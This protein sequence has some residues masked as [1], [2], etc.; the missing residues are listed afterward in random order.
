ML[1]F[2]VAWEG[3]KLDYKDCTS[4]SDTIIELRKIDDDLRGRG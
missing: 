2:P 4:N 3:D 1:V